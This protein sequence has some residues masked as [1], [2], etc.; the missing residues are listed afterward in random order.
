MG[1]GPMRYVTVITKEIEI[2]I[3]LAYPR[4]RSDLRPAA[5]VVLREDAD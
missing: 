4:T 2:L 5:Y 1:F 3:H